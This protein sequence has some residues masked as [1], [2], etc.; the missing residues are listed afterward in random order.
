MRRSS[1]PAP[2]CSGKAKTIATTV[3]RVR[4]DIG[5]AV[6]AMDTTAREV[7]GAGNIA[8]DAT[9]A[10][11]AMV[12][13]ISRIAEQSGDVA[14]LAQSQAQFSSSVAGVFEALD[15]SAVRASQA[16]VNAAEA[17]AAQRMSIDELSRSAAQL[18]QTAARM[19]AL[20]LRHTAE[21]VAVR[22]DVDATLSAT[23]PAARSSRRTAPRDSPRVAA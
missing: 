18:S 20:V 4:D 22:A 16:A 8:R 7:A 19:R 11:G 17:A 12:E 21:H 13:G 23:S 15:G 14:A 9:A 3:H 2:R 1:P 6:Q 5:G 10:L